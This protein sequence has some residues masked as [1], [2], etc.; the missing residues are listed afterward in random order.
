MTASTP[1]STIT[2]SASSLSANV[3]SAS[4]STYA[5]VSA[6][7]TSTVGAPSATPSPVGQLGGPSELYEQVLSVSFRVQNTGD[8]AGNEV[9]QLY[10]TLLSG[11]G[12]PPKVLRGFSR[13]FLQSGHTCS[14]HDFL[15]AE[16]LTLTIIST[17][18][19][20]RALLACVIL[21]KILE[22]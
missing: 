17:A 20:L 11:Y 14:R 22:C 9:S 21:A 5:P 3:S 6:N 12:E 7:A 13:N 15:K 18:T 4:V 10:L 2:P 16:L 8:V 19:S 1:A